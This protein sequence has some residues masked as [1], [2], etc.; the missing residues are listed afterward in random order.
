M[1]FDFRNPSGHQTC[2]VADRR[3]G[4]CQDWVVPN[5]N[6]TAAVSSAIASKRIMSE[7]PL[8]RFGGESIPKLRY[9]APPNGSSPEGSLNALQRTYQAPENSPFV[10]LPLHCGHLQSLKLLL[11]NLTWARY[12]SRPSR[13]QLTHGI[14]FRSVYPLSRMIMKYPCREL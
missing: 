10:R 3:L 8:R 12:M 7:G 4:R 5:R 6:A 2:A 13:G 1:L 14:M 11:S 9:K